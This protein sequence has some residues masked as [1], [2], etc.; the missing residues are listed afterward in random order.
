LESRQELPEPDFRALFESVPDLCVVLTPDLRIVAVS[1]AYL[2]AAMTTREQMLGKDI[3][4]H[5]FPDNSDEVEMARCRNLRTSLQRV[6]DNLLQDVMTVQ[7]YHVRRPESEGGGF[8]AR[9]W[10]PV[11]T[12]VLGRDGELRYILHAVRDVTGFVQ[13]GHEV[14]K[15]TELEFRV[16]ERTKQLQDTIR[17]LE[18]FSYSVSHDLKAPLRAIDGFSRIL[19]EE[20]ADKLDADGRHVLNVI[21]TSTLKMGN[22]IESLLDLARLGRK[23]MRLVDTDMQAL[24]KT[25]F[26]EIRAAAPERSVE[27]H[28]GPLH[29]VKADPVLMQQVLMNLLSNAFK[30]TRHRPKAVIQVG[31]ELR[32]SSR[33]IV[34]WV[35]DNGVGFEMQYVDKL[36][37]VF[38]RLHT[39]REFD[40][41][42]IGLAIVQRAVH[43]HSGRVWAESVLGEGATFY[44]SL[45]AVQTTTF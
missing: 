6:I 45:P 5:V 32:Q 42:G 17:E 36:F 37:G 1:D 30:F 13:E 44:F 33:E 9:Y 39:D 4:H 23:Q 14:E 2:R 35:R 21:R 20:Y 22:L 18:S 43:R 38:Q 34:F 25:I 28:C 15:I 10:S 29:R 26:H 3:F 24:V 7:K 41:T 11:N 16:H 31:S 8:E 19:I 12:P 27:L 40:G